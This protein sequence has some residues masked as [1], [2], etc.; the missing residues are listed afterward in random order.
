LLQGKINFKNA[1]QSAKP[2][3]GG[4]LDASQF[5]CHFSNLF[6]FPF[7]PLLFKRDCCLKMGS[8]TSAQESTCQVL[9]ALKIIGF[10]V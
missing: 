7:M 5:V 6:C 8:L 4:V 9:E 2:K 1:T 3:A 10:E